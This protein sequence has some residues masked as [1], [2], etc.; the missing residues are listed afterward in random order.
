MMDYGKCLYFNVHDYRIFIYVATLNPRHLKFMEN[1]R[2]K[3]M[4][5]GDALAM[6]V[7]MF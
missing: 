7:T 1:G 6:F 2:L 4:Q 5:G 3:H